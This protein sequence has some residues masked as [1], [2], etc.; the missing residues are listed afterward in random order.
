MTLSS[1]LSATFMTFCFLMVAPAYAADITPPAAAH[2]EPT[3]HMASYVSMSIAYN[4]RETRQ[5]ATIAQA[6]DKKRA[7]IEA[8]F[9]AMGF[10]KYEFTGSQFVLTNDSNKDAMKCAAGPLTFDKD[11]YQLD[12]KMSYMVSPGDKAPE[13]VEQMTDKGYLINAA[14]N[15]RK[16]CN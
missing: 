12:A 10:T 15:E 13:F 2:K 1:R 7:E 14:V 16:E 11:Q 8:A 9:K 4:V 3:C 5:N 6:M